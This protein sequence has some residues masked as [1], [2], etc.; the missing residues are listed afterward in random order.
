MTEQP[1]TQWRQSQDGGW[2]YLAPDGYWYEGKRSS[3]A[4]DENSSQWEPPTQDLPQRT[5]G[6]QRAARVKKRRLI[7]G[8]GGLAL[9]A[10]IVVV[11][12]FVFNSTGTH[13][14]PPG[15]SVLSFEQNI[16]SQVKNTGANGFDVPSASSI[17]CIMPSNWA[18]GRTFTCYVYNR[19]NTG[20]G[21][22]N[23]T[24]LPTESGD[25]WNSNNQWSPAG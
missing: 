2:Q 4:A 19:H 22:V 5:R 12:I 10:V 21:T 13:G 20:L 14:T 6:Q 15:T 23:G 11:V 7:F 17:S 1:P 24:V 9:V 18:T 3:P 25:A 16:L 8:L